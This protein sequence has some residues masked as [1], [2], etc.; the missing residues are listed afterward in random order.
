MQ[1]LVH[2]FPTRVKTHLVALAVAIV[3]ACAA[4]FV[5]GD[6]AAAGV[7]ISSGR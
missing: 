6:D 5:A 4:L 3:A 2:T 7:V 1:T